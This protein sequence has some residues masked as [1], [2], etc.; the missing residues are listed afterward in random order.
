MSVAKNLFDVT[1]IAYLVAAVYFLVVSALGEATSYSAAAAL[2][3]L[4]SLALALR[5][6]WF[7]SVPWRVATAAFVLVLFLAQ[8][9]AASSQTSSTTSLGSILINGVFLLIF[10]GVLLSAV[11]DSIKKESEE[12]K[13]EEEKEEEQEKKKHEAKKLTY[14][15]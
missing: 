13:E 1:N 11:H 3:C 9:V 14:E 10:L 4:V 2:L 5:K 15:V 12:E 6:E 8:M 7:F